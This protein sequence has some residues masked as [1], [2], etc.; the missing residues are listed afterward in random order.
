MAKKRLNNWHRELILN[1]ML[2]E[3]NSLPEDNENVIELMK[4]AIGF[5]NK[6]I[7]ETYPESDMVIL[8]KY[9]LMRK[10]TCLKFT[11][12]GDGVFGIDLY[13]RAIRSLSGVADALI[14]DIPSS[15]GC[16]NNRVFGIS[17][18]GREAIESFKEA[19]LEAKSQYAQKKS[20]FSS[21]VNNAKYLED[22]EEVVPL[23]E[24]VRQRITGSNSSLVAIN[25]E[26]IQDIA[27]EFKKNTQ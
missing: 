5:A 24:D 21:F 15:G 25:P 12:D 8:R 18:D 1:W 19:Y 11:V 6:A 4:T 23:P 20:K 17:Q 7:R 13:P 10:D 16:F 3:K 2:K 14:E 27:A 22:I 26:I 9:N